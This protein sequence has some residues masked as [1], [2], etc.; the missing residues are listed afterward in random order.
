MLRLGI[1]SCYFKVTARAVMSNSRLHLSNLSV[2]RLPNVTD[3]VMW[4]MMLY[5]IPPDPGGQLIYFECQELI[6][7][8]RQDDVYHM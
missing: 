7:L 1:F 3:D 2:D 5:Q 4:T 8:E 6:H